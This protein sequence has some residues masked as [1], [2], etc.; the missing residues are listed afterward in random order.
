MFQSQISVD[1]GMASG[2]STPSTPTS[3]IDFDVRIA[4]ESD[5]TRIVEFLR[6]FFFRDEPLN[7][8]L[9]LVTDEKPICEDL[10]KFACKDIG[11]PSIVAELD[12]KLIGVC[13]NGILYKDKKDDPFVCEDK[14]FA[15][16]CN[17]LEHVAVDSD[18]FQ[19]FPDADKAMS[20]KIIS[21][22]GTYRGK[23]IAKQ[24]MAKTR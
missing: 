20:V 17:L 23:G 18:P 14:E 13:L 9:G 15:K 22:D 19:H 5:R 4:T 8:Y 3:P 6:K 2:P 11:D 1:S 24:L 10:E 16:I 7:N 12:G 21:V